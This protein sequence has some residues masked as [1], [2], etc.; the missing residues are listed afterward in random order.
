M[1]WKYATSYLRTQKIKKE[2][3]TKKTKEQAKILAQS[4]WPLS[5]WVT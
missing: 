3:K 5:D 1:P 4:R 2:T